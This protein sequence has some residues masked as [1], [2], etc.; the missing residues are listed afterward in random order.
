M[1]RLPLR[2]SVIATTLLLL[3][4]SAF[5]VPAP[6]LNLAWTSCVSEGGTSNLDF[7]C[8]DDFA[9]LS[10]ASTFVLAAPI[11]GVTGVE[12]LIDLISATPTL[13]AWWDFGTGGC[14]EGNLF[15]LP[16]APAGALCTDWAL[17]AAAGGLAAYS[18]ADGS[19]PP[20]DQAAHRRAIGRRA[21]RRA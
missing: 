19:L 13:P 15:A 10:L 18:S 1:D 17:G 5:A 9:Q 16:A 11:S 8:N 3:A 20:E 21:S 2:A 4:S 14:G 6:G 12:I 7:A